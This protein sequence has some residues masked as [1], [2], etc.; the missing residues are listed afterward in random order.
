MGT[1]DERLIGVRGAGEY[2]G[3][4]SLLNPDGKRTASIRACTPVRALEITRADFDALLRRHPTMAYELTRVMSDCLT[5]AHNAALYEAQEKN[6]QLREAYEELKA[7]QAQVIEKE[8]LEHELEVARQ[9]QESMLPREMPRLAG[10]DFGARMV[11]TRAVG[12][13]FFDFVPLDETH[14]GLAI[15]DVSGKGTPAAMFMALSRSLL[16]AEAWRTRSPRAVL[17]NVNRLLLEMNDSGMFVTMLYGVLDGPAR[18]FHWARA[19][20]DLPI[21]FRRGRQLALPEARPATPLGLVPEARLDVRRMRLHEGDALL[22]Y[23]DGVTEA[24]DERD[25][26]FGGAR[27]QG[28]LSASCGLPAQEIC[29]RLVET[30]GEHRGSAAQSDDITVVALRVGDEGRRA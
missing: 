2:I 7:A 25:E 5:T 24:V 10:F 14:V 29:N 1:A 22:L 4:M 27:L 3:E 6:R 16:R 18:Q 11:P 9:I 19:G 26:L 30:V 13:D 20:H 28:S 12:G 23:T 21:V 17:Q 15:A 8:K